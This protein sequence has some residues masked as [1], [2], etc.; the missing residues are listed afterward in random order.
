M[1]YT[2]EAPIGAEVPC[3]GGEVYAMSATDIEN[4]QHACA[5]G[6]GRAVLLCIP[7]ARLQDP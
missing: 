1:W 3:L 2:W 7:G 5:L 6:C 4:H